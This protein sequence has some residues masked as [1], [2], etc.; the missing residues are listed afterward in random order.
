M[1]LSQDNLRKYGEQQT[2]E[3]K[4]SLSLQ[5][6]ALEYQKTTEEIHMLIEERDKLKQGNVDKE[7]KDYNCWSL[8]YVLPDVHH[9][10]RDH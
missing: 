3:F 7:Q 9:T 8:L 4:K 5:K 6:E 10:F 1:K 2:L